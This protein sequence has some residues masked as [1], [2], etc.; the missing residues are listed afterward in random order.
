MLRVPGVVLSDIVLDT[1]ASFVLFALALVVANTPFVLA[2]VLPFVATFRA[3]LLAIITAVFAR[4]IRE[5]KVNV[6]DFSNC[7]FRGNYRGS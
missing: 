7:I 2:T 6:V 5:E 4:V 1:L 3:L